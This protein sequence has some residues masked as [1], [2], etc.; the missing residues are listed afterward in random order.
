MANEV[1]LGLGG[2][3]NEKFLGDKKFRMAVATL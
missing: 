3:A 1:S 2:G